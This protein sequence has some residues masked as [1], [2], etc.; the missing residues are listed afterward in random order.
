MGILVP[1]QA[2]A[3][4][5]AVYPSLRHLLDLRDGGW[6]FLPL[7]AAQLDGFRQWPDGWTDCVRVRHAGDALGLRMDRDHRITW[8]HAAG[9][10]EVVRELLLLPPPG[11][12]LA[13]RL[14]RG[15]GPGLGR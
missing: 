12:R 3:A 14:A 13:P 9:L 4:A 15:H 8:E 1:G 2:E 7:V 11:H 5:C 6:K 10:G